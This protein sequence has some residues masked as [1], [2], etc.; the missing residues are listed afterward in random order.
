[1][2]LKRFK[3]HH[4]LKSKKHLSGKCK[5]A[6]NVRDRYWILKIKD[7][8]RIRRTRTEAFKRKSKNYQRDKGVF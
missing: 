1:M 4:F 7:R 2:T 6:K 5:T 3:M 8:Q